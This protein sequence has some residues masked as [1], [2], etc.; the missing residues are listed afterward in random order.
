ME[1]QPKMDGFAAGRAHCNY[2]EVMLPNDK[3]IDFVKES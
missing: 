3:M 1:V 2:S